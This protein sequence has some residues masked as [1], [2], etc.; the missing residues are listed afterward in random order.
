MAL[1]DDLKREV[2]ERFGIADGAGALLAALLRMIEDDGLRG[3]LAR[4]E[5]VGLGELAGSWISRGANSSLSHLQTE[6]AIGKS[7]LAKLAA[8]TNLPPVT[9]TKALAFMIPAVVDRLTPDG[10]VSSAA[11][12]PPALSS[13]RGSSPLRWILPILL[14]ALF[15]FVSYWLFVR[16]NQQTVFANSRTVTNNSNSAA[17]VVPAAQK[18]DSRVS[19]KAAGGKYIASGVVV[20]EAERNQIVEALNK[21]FGA[22]NVDAS[23]LRIDAN[24]K[25]A[26]WLAKFY[27][28]LPSLKSWTS[29]ELSFE[30]E[31][32]LRAVGDIPQTVIERIKIL[33]AGWTLPPIF[34]GTGI[35]A[36]KSANEQAQKALETAATPQQVVDAL[37][38]SIINFANNESKVPADAQPILQKAAEVLKNAP[39][40]TKIEIGGYTDNRGKPDKNLQLSKDRANSVTSELVKLGVKTETLTAKGYGQENPKADN[41]TE[42]GRFQNRRIEYKITQ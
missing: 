31:N 28:L 29:G 30:G 16:P 22:A 35:E 20:S 33:F 17:V 25:G 4:F 6:D 18:V 13:N 26:S 2:G 14:L 24:A 9:A 7:D 11:S 12:L 42:S 40:G 41:K 1:F 5:R 38:L 27:E 32:R 8:E 19:L 39:A 23:G 3:F 36:Q 37:N 15:L 10:V 34:L 21:E